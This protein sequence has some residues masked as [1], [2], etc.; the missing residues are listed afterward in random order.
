MNPN[1]I[2]KA[3]MAMKVTTFHRRSKQKAIEY[4]GGK[5]ITCGYNKS[6]AALVFHHRDP[7]EKSFTVSGKIAKWERLQPELDKCDLLCSN[8][9]HEEHERLD[10]IGRAEKYAEIRTHVRERDSIN[11]VTMNGIEPNSNGS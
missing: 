2:R 4:K 5:C 1:D 8:C 3:Y 6:P 9:H 11:Y 7:A 10:E